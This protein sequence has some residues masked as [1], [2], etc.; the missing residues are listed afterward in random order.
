MFSFKKQLMCVF[1]IGIFY[2]DVFSWF[3]RFDP[4]VPLIHLPL[5]IVLLR[6]VAYYSGREAPRSE[7]VFFFIFFLFF[8]FGVAIVQEDF[9]Y[10]TNDVSHTGWRMQDK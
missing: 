10:D 8:V 3:R 7:V 5:F 1:Y 4:Q 9:V 6:P 2:K